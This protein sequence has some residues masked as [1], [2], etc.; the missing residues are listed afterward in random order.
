MRPSQIGAM[1]HRQPLTR[2]AGFII[3]EEMEFPRSRRVRGMTKSAEIHLV[4]EKMDS[5][6]RGNDG[7]SCIGVLSN[8]N[9]RRMRTNRRGTR[10]HHRG[11]RTHRRGTRTHHRGMRTHHRGM[12]THRR[13]TRTHRRG[14]RTH[15]RGMRT[16]R[17]GM[18]THRRFVPS[19]AARPS[20]GDDLQAGCFCP[21][22]S[23]H[24]AT[25]V[26]GLSDMLS[27]PCSTSHCA[28][29]G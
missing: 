26:S 2:S 27:I 29:S 23:S 1:R 17:R 11:M 7:V 6:V 12:R 16:H 20:T 21:A 5:R 15:H 25:T 13:G 18:R 8:A 22:S 28:R 10:T 24:V 4:R 14:T 3:A 19:A 9:R